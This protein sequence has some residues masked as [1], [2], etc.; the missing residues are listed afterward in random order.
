MTESPSDY[1]AL[2]R[3]VRERENFKLEINQLQNKQVESDAQIARL[4]EQLRLYE[5]AVAERDAALEDLKNQI[6]SK[7]KSLLGRVRE[8]DETIARL[9]TALQNKHRELEEMRGGKKR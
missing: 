5:Q 7:N 2:L 3:G 8:Q 9:Q 4:E 6:A 1:A